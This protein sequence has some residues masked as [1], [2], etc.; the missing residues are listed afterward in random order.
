MS[1]SQNIE[2]K[3]SWR[4]E[5]LKWICGFA[6]AQ[7][8]RLYIGCDDDGN[9]VGV[10][11]SKRLLEDIPNKIQTTLGILADVNLLNDGGKEYIEIAVK[12]STYPVNYKGEF[13]Y[14][15]G[16]TKQQLRGSALTTFLLSKTGF[17]WDAASVDDITVSDLDQESFD[18]FRRDGIR[19]GRLRS[20]DLEMSNEELLK[21]LGLFSDGKLK[22]AAVMLFYRYPQR[23]ITGSYVKIGK[24][25]KG[26]DLLY[27]DEVNGSLF[28]IADRIFE[29]IYLKYLTAGISY[30]KEVRIETYPY[31]REAVREAVFNALMHCNWASGIP[32]Q[33]RLNDDA[34]Y[35][36]N[37]CILPL[38]WTQDT[39]MEQHTSQPFNPDIANAFFRAGY[40]EAWGRGIKK[41]CDTCREYGSPAPEFQLSGEMLTVKFSALMASSKADGAENE[42][43]E[44]ENE[45]NEAIE[46]E[47]E[48][49]EA[50]KDTESNV[51]SKDETAS[52]ETLQAR[53]L[54]LIK[55]NEKLTQNELAAALGCSR[56]SVQRAM[57]VLT[58][59]G[60]LVR[61]GSPRNG[62]WET[63]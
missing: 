57:K 52:A 55:E 13:H 38:N 62:Y 50:K 19:S 41:I 27:Q 9:V 11:D 54:V 12:P 23:Y 2:W 33:I 4:D 29:L 1:E 5:Y 6:N 34:M 3:Q 8:G 17:H 10:K 40:V 36:S 49:Y 53:I 21:Q 35:I 24:F 7:G 31:P 18:I 14:R 39:L 47:N 59:Q 28:I 48:A 20:A 63:R 56:T 32:I 25:G 61:V 37:A 30:D 26:A 45:A 44:A 42:A 46:A 51:S 60:V 43:D 16:S 58:D 15:T 22:R